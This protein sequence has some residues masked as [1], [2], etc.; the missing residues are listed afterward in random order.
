MG[1]HPNRRAGALTFAL[2]LVLVLGLAV[3]Q[4][5]L[6]SRAQ[7]ERPQPVAAPEG[8]P[9]E[10]RDL[11][12]LARQAQR[13]TVY[14]PQVVAPPLPRVALASLLPAESQQLPGGVYLVDSLYIPAGVTVTATGPVSF[15]ISRTATVS[16]TLAS[17]CFD[18]SIAAQGAVAVGGVIDNRCGSAT[19]D[20]GDLTLE[21]ASGNIRVG[22]PSN[23]ELVNIQ[24]DGQVQISNDTGAPS[25]Q[26]E[27]LPNQRS[28]APLAPVCSARAEAVV[29]SASAD[30]PALVQFAGQAADPD[31][32]AVSY[33]WDF[34]DGAASSEPN[35]AH[36]YA[37]WGVYTASLTVTDD[38]GQS[39]TATLSLALDDAG[40]NAPAGPGVWGAPVTLVQGEGGPVIFSALADDPQGEEVSY[41]WDFGDGNSSVE[42]DP[43]HTYAAPGRYSYTLTATDT[44]GNSAVSSGAVYVYDATAQTEQVRSIQP[45]GR[46]AERPDGQFIVIG[47]TLILGGGFNA[48]GAAAAGRNGKNFF[49]TWNGNV[50][51][52]AGFA[53]RAQDGGVGNNAVAFG[54]AAGQR[55]GNGGSVLFSVLGSLVINAGATLTSGKGGKGGSA[56]ALAVA[57]GQ[58]TALGGRGGN[59]GNIFLAAGGGIAILGA[60][61]ATFG[62]G[63]AGGLAEAFGWGG[64]G[65]ACPNGQAGASA[66]ATGGAGGGTAA[67]VLGAF[68]LVLGMN[69][70]RID[71]GLAGKGGDADAIGGKGQDMACVGHTAGGRGGAATAVA[72]KGGS[73]ARFIMPIFGAVGAGSFRGG[74]S[75]TATALAGAGGA[76]TGNGAAPG[77][78]ADATGGAG[79]AATAT[80]P[81]GGRGRTNGNAGDANATGGAGGGATATGANGGVGAAGGAAD[82][83]GGKG[84]GANARAGRA[85]AGA[86][87]GTAVSTG[88]A[89]GAAGATGGAGGNG[90]CLVALDGGAGGAATAS[91]GD[92]GAAKSVGPGIVQDGGPGG[93]AFVLGGNGGNGASC[94]LVG[95]D[96]GVGGDA[97]ALGGAGGPPNGLPGLPFGF[98]GNGGNGGNGLF[99]GAGG[100]GGFG[101]N[102]DHGLPGNPGAPRLNAKGRDGALEDKASC[103]EPT[104]TPITATPVT[105]TPVTVT[106]VTATPVT[107]TPITVTATV[108]ATKTPVTTTPVTATPVT[109]TPL[110][111]TPV[112]ATPL[113]T[114]PVTATPVTAVATVRPVPP[115]AALDGGGD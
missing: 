39:C 66:S 12:A 60:L 83:A 34:G 3:P 114:T 25:W 6:G 49:V 115:P 33:A 15:V 24:T 95:G 57:P 1:S 8:P 93:I 78:A 110:T 41:L 36:E 112:T 17:D 56:T 89:G 102:A 90:N 108:T 104:V 35:P 87:N 113:T 10:P 77:G 75:G 76:A 21:T 68:G 54:R 13:S 46:A 67:P 18:I 51:L 58:A 40:T 109:A 53:A 96:G 97:S 16:G 94:C 2:V 48:G 70:V 91:G 72:G 31:G 74:D 105:G 38:D 62:D 82:A 71:G 9:A 69:N 20:G 47:N 5:A 63:G 88:G 86:V 61:T 45:H 19:G 65:W 55:G 52:Q 22:D 79:G 26:Y 84:G 11:E 101:F 7:G 85:G 106:P 100:A 73:S 27:V 99:P 98:A 44:S 107:P 43:D 81:D 23:P 30:A 111:T 50:I 103:E 29:S 80:G 28:A 92:G 32:G 42:V 59:G 4:A 64:A 14:L 37:G